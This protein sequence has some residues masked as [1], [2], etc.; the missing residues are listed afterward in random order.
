MPLYFTHLFFHLL[1]L[2]NA[3]ADQALEPILVLLLN[4]LGICQ[5]LLFFQWARILVLFLGYC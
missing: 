1:L 2:G 3:A 4:D 5:L